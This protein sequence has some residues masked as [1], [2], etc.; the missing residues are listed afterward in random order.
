V[1]W[2]VT[3][4]CAVVAALAIAPSARAEGSPPQVWIDGYQSPTEGV[5]AITV[6]GR[7]VTAGATVGSAT[8]TLNGATIATGALTCAAPPCSE[9]SVP[10]SFDTTAYPDGVYDLK[11][12]VSDSTGAIGTDDHPDFEIWNDRPRGSSTATLTIGSAVPTPQ[13][14][15]GSDPGGGGG[16]LG[17]SEGACAKPKLSMKLS[18]RPLRIRHGVPVLVNGKRYRFTGRLT[19]LVDGQ[20]RS[21]PTRTR[22]DLRAIIDGKSHSKGRTTVGSG[23]RIDVRIAATSSRTL[24]FR[25]T[26]EDGQVTRVRIKVQ[27]VKVAKQQH[28]KG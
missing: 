4:I 19:C 24:E 23:G 27:V 14:G 16:V 18:Q 6:H 3:A 8:V 2:I 13:P 11:I 7:A 12:T 10:V 21:A 15:G 26:T 25:F 1:G 20:R 28:K 17:A 9:G 5:F 22:I